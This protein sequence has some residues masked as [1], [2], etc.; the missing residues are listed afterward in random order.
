MSD[1]L[2]REFSFL[3]KSIDDTQRR[4]VAS[5]MSGKVAEIKGKLVR[6]E[7][8]DD[9]PRTGKKFLSPWVQLQEAAGS[10][11]SNMPVAIGDPM[12]LLSPNGELG[13]QSLAMRDSHTNDAP[14]PANNDELV[15]A[16]GDC[17]LRMQDGLLLLTQGGAEIRLEAGQSKI[18]SSKHTHNNKNVGDTHKHGG[19]LPGGAKTDVPS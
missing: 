8:G 17:A 1:Q 18:K 4:L 3:W 10:T 19:V 16:H 15:I 5:Q 7:L 9:D 11:S 13:A 2:A 12:R 6:L 14:N